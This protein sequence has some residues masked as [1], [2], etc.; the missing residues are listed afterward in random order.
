MLAI[1]KYPFLARDQTGVDELAA[2]AADNGNDR[3]AEYHD[4][5]RQAAA[6]GFARMSRDPKGI[7][8]LQGLAKKYFDAAAEKRKAADGKPKTDA[9]EADKVLEKEKKKVDDIKVELIKLTKDTSKSAEDI[10]AATKKVKDAELALKG[11]KLKH[12]E[13]TRPFKELD[14]LAKAYKSFGRLFQHHIA[15][16][17]TG[18]RCKDDLDCYAATLKMKPEE[19]TKHLKAHIPDIEAV[20]EKKEKEWGKDDLMRLLEGGVERGML[21]I[22]KRGQAAA[23]YT[24]LLL[25]NATSDNRIIRQSILLALP[26]IAKLPCQTCEAKLDV[27]LKAG[28]G[29]VALKG[30]QVET[31]MMRNYFSWA[32][33]K[34]PTKAAAPA[35]EAA[36]PAAAPDA[37]AEPKKGEAEAKDE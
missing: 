33:G 1:V 17:E 12:R 11:H 25:D 35:P 23:K 3:E 18:V 15:R 27:A 32:G 19:I 26:K 8:V 9:A 14:N 30:L 31:T 24:D 34:T 6:E 7:A 13:A 16:I 36:A 37:K 22:G 21:E 29:K 28:E 4:Q 10:K 5:L 20:N 2:I